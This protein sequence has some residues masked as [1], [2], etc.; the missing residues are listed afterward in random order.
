MDALIN[1]VAVV[2][3]SGTSRRP[4][5]SSHGRTTRDDEI[6]AAWP[7]PTTADQPRSHSCTAR[8]ARHHDDAGEE[9]EAEVDPA[10]WRSRKAPSGAAAWPGSREAILQFRQVQEPSAVALADR[11]GRATA[12]L[13]MRRVQLSRGTWRRHR[14]IHAEPGMPQ[15]QSSQREIAR[16]REQDWPRQRQRAQ[17][18]KRD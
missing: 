12:E 9:D 10:A 18:H 15:L 11:D 2:E 6:A 3:Q 13:S 1:I 4:S 16:A 8:S 7:R 5:R 17:S 14:S